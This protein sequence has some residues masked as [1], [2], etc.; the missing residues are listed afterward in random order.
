MLIDTARCLG[1][2]ADDDLSA[3][4]IQSSVQHGDGPGTGGY[5]ADDVFC[6]PAADRA[7]HPRLR[8]GP[9]ECSRRPA[10]LREAGYRATNF[11]LTDDE[12]G[13]RRLV[14]ELHADAHDAVAIGGV[15]NG[16]SPSWP[17]TEK[18]TLW[19][20]RVLKLIAEHSPGT[21]I[22]LVW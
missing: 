5:S 9:R 7:A 8:E 15:I 22:A 13:D 3:T 12:E 14:A 19:F 16:Q 4:E 21:R 18:T 6:R 20:E 2:Q 17:P 11:A 10:R 1:G